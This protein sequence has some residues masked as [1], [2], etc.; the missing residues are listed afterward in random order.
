MVPVGV[1]ACRLPNRHSIE[2]LGL[3]ACEIAVYRRCDGCSAVN[4]RE[5]KSKRCAMLEVAI[6]HTH[7][8]RTLPSHHPQR[9]CYCRVVGVVLHHIILYLLVLRLA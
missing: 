2:N 4:K 3:A 8:D 7:R 1:L 6:T 9:L 5:M